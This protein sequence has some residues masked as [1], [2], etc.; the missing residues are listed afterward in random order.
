LVFAEL[1]SADGSLP[2]F[3]HCSSILLTL[4]LAGDGGQ[5]LL[6]AAP[7]RNRPAQV[8]F[9]GFLLG[10]SKLIVTTP[11]NTRMKPRSSIRRCDDILMSSESVSIVAKHFHGGNTGSNFV[12]DTQENRIAALLDSGWLQGTERNGIRVH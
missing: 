10:S 12:G 6:H 5:Q 8:G 9:T 4:V 3:W 1:Q 7:K 2:E 11:W